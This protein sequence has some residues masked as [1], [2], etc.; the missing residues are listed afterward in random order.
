[1]N[2]IR[3]TCPYCGVGCGVRATPSGEALLPVN[4]D[5]AHPRTRQALR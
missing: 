3:T 5:E 2:D 1:M 4:G